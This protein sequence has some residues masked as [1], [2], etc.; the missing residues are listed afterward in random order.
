MPASALQL[1]WTPCGRRENGADSALSHLERPYT[2]DERHHL[3]LVGLRAPRPI[4]VSPA[5]C[6]LAG[7]ILVQGS[8]P[9]TAQCACACSRIS[10]SCAGSPDS[11]SHPSASACSN[12]A[13]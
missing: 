13:R 9:A 3:F 10:C 1:L 7:P 4:V 8:G 5:R 11:E 6:S 2:G 12:V